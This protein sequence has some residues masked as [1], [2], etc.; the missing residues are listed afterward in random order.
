MI[1]LAIFASGNGSNAKKLIE[2]IRDLDSLKLCILITDN[3]HAGVITHCKEYNINYKVCPKNNISKEEHE[4]LII[5]EL[6]AYKIDYILLAGY[7]RILSS[8][9]IIHF[10]REGEKHSRI[11]NIHPSLLPHH[12]GL[13][14]YE[15][16]YADKS[17]FS[18][19]TLHYVDPGMDSGEIIMQAKLDK[20]DQEPLEDFIT[21]GLTLEHQI[22][23]Y[24]IEVLNSNA[25]DISPLEE[26]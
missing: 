3:E 6:K 2:C 21:R 7:M 14:A 22:Y 12:K 9:F 13:N 25:K 24:F 10:S 15:K 23:P 4:N 19:I 20:K 17:S 8:K 26:I 1:N 5:E 18:G 11:V 16:A